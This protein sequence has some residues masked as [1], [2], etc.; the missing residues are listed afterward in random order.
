[1][2]F[3]R[4]ASEFEAAVAALVKE[5]AGHV[6]FETTVHG[7]VVQTTKRTCVLARAKIPCQV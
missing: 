5:R 7:F 1:M 6:S 4:L 2:V 3:I